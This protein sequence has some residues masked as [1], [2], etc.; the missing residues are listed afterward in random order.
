MAKADKYTRTH[1][2]K[3][4]VWGL[5]SRHKLENDLRL[6]DMVA[7]LELVKFEMM[8]GAL[9]ESMNESDE[10]GDYDGQ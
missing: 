10:E 9:E 2:F 8:V 6:Q 5:I 3:E 4:E 7:A 1:Q